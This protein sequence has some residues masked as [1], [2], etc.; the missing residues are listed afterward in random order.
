MTQLTQ[1]HEQVDALRREAQASQEQ[2]DALRLEVQALRD[3][4]STQHAWLMAIQ[5]HINN[6]TIATATVIPVI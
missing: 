3:Q 4:L 5:S 1:L 6:V 2:V